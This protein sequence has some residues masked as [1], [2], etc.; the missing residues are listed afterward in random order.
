MNKVILIGR[1]TKDIELK[2]TQN[3]NS[4]TSFTVAVNRIFQSQDP[5]QP[6]AD[7]IN[8]VAWNRTAELMNQYVGKGSQVAVD[9]RIQTRNYENQEGRRIYVTEV[10]VDGQPLGSTSGAQD[11]DAERATAYETDSGSFDV[12]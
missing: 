11:D 7:F 2:K 5:N 8:C 10:V 4:V 3:G 12:L 1:L 9:G 6:T